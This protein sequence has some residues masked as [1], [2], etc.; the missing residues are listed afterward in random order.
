MQPVY[1]Y[2]PMQNVTH[3]V[4]QPVNKWGKNIYLKLK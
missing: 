2:L 4:D 3:P 1:S